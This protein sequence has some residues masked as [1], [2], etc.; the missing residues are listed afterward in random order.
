MHGGFRKAPAMI[1]HRFLPRLATSAADLAD[2]FV[3]W[4]WRAICVAV[5]FDLG[6]SAGRDDRPNRFLGQRLI[7]LPLVVGAVAIKSVDRAVDLL[8]QVV[9]LI[10]VVA[11]VLGQYLGLDFLRFG[12]HR[13]VQLAPRAAFGFAMLAGSPRPLV[14]SL[15]TPSRILPSRTPRRG[16]YVERDAEP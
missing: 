12:V 16:N 9:H 14:Q 13:Q 4:K 10:C 8:Q 15:W 2:R 7:D 3:S 6:V 5:L 11:A 1:A